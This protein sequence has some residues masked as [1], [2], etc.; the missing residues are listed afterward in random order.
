MELDSVNMTA[1]LTNEHVQ[2]MLNCLNSGPSQ[3]LPEAPGGYGS[4][5]NATQ[6]APYETASGLA[7]WDGVTPECRLLFSPWSDPV[8]LRAGV[9]L[10]Q[11]LAVFLALHRF[12]PMLQHKHVLVRTENTATVAYINHQGFYACRMSQ[13]A[14]H[15]LL[16]SQTR[17]K[18]LRAVHI[19][20]E[21]NRAANALSQQ[22]THPREWR[23]HPQAVQL[24]WSRSSKAQLFY[25]L[26]EAPFGS[27]ALAH[28][29]PQGLLKYAFPPVSLLA[30]TLCKIREDE[31]QL[32]GPTEMLDRSGA[33]LSA[34]RVEAEAVPSTL[35]VIT[36]MQGG[37]L[38]VGLLRHSLR[39]CAFSPS[40]SGS[41]VPR[42][43]LEIYVPNHLHLTCLP[44][45]TC[46]QPRNVVQDCG[47]FHGSIPN[48]SLDVTLE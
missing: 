48:T 10:G 7:T 44:V 14:R 39:I 4:R 13:L 30:Q 41:S 31:E 5:S 18:S 23:L 21:L 26:T 25:S 12:L 42:S 8:F 9:P 16:W 15:L 24:I 17:L 35:K 47:V 22:L 2:S 43:P 32:R 1:R 38:G 46:V 27:D 20:G 37:R 19:P 34:G 11:L 33:C 36:P 6:P 40:C 29:S 45:S 28:S 3:I